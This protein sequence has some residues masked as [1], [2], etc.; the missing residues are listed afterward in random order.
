MNT[1]NEQKGLV[2]SGAGPDVAGARRGPARMRVGR[3]GVA[4]LLLLAMLVGGAFPSFSQID[5]SRYTVEFL[6]T[7]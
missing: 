6:Y 7:T 2:Q 3:S 1:E 4:V 5:C